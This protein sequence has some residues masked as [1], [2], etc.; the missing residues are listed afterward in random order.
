MIGDPVTDHTL[1]LPGVQD[2]SESPVYRS[3][4]LFPT[5]FYP[6]KTPFSS[7]LFSPPYGLLSTQIWEVLWPLPT[8]HVG[9]WEHRGTERESV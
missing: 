3:A 4:L 9:S 7:L 6:P 8:L 5:P 1:G 2:M